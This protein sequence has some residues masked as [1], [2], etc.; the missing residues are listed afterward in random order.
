MKYRP[1]KD[2]VSKNGGVRLSMHPRL[3]DQLV[4]LAVEE[5]PAD[6][7]SSTAEEVLA[8]RL[9]IRARRQYG[10]VLT[11]VFVAAAAAGVAKLVCGWHGKRNAHRVLLL[12][13]Q[14]ASKDGR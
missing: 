7:S 9:T 2:Y 8:A 13:W 12:G 3:R 5:F 4:D 14:S 11:F 1:L 10:K 6:A